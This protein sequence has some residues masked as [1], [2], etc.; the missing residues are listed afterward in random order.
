VGTGCWILDA[1]KKN[2]SKIKG[3]RSNSKAA[4][5]AKNLNKD[6]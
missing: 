1:G 3:K 2:R 6:I 5:Y 4:E